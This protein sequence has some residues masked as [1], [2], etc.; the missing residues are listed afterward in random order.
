MALKG[1]R[2]VVQTDI[3][4][5]CD[6]AAVAGQVLVNTTSGSGV[7]QGDSRGVST[8]SASSS[9]K[10]V[11]GI[12]MHKVRVLD[13]TT[14]HRNFHNGE[15][16]TNEPC[17]QM[18]K[19]WLVTNIIVGTPAVGGTAYLSSSGYLTPTV[20][21][22]GGLVATPKVGRFESIKDADGYVKVS[23]EVPSV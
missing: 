1:P 23:V 18:V 13:E 17:T 12:V 16:L 19:G 21:A 11:T 15:M 10:V 9:G 22:N 14:Q 5:T 6:V 20:D 8:V 2:D 4:R 7:S 3:M